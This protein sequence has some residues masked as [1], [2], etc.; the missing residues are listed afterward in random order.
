MNRANVS[1]FRA[2]KRGEGEPDSK[3]PTAT[4]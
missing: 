3:T 4:A 2:R 1:A